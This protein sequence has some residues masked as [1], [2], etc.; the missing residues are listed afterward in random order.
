MNDRRMEFHPFKERGVVVGGWIRTRK[1]C[2]SGPWRR[3]WRVLGGSAPSGVKTSAGRVP[4]ETLA[5]SL[6]PVPLCPGCCCWR[7]SDEASG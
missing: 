5:A 3:T 4:S 6:C 7:G 1:G 2:S